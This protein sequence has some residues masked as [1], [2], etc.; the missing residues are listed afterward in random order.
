M[1][2]LEENNF[3]TSTE[4]KK[5]SFGFWLVEILTLIVIDQAVQYFVQLSGAS[6]FRNYQFAFSLP[7]PH[8]LMYSIYIIA[9]VFILWYVVHSWATLTTLARLGW[10]LVIAGGLSN[11]GERILLGYVR[12]FI[13]IATGVF[14]IADGFILLG[15][16]LILTQNFRRKL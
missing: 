16:I 2:N 9:I 4:R 5:Y 15:A 10:G 6:I 13:Y 3:E 1:D 8:V 7:L 12:D 14:N 11:I